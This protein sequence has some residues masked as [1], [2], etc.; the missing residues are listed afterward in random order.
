M[1]NPPVLQSSVSRKPVE[2]T[3]ES[4]RLTP[5]ELAIVDA[6]LTPQEL[7]MVDA[8]LTPAE[9]A[10]E[11]ARLRLVPLECKLHPSGF[12]AFKVMATSGL[13]SVAPKKSCNEGSAIWTDARRCLLVRG[14]S[15]AFP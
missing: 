1:L 9:L 4:A 6:K 14:V 8:I 15:G 2:L 3:I 5:V 7:A 13:L 12:R 10:I 11:S